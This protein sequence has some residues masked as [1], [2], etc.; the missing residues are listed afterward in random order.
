L[1]LERH[2][3]TLTTEA[4]NKWYNRKMEL[5]LREME[6]SSVLAKVMSDTPYP[7]NWLQETWREVL[8]YQFHDILPGSSIKRVYDESLA[9][10]QILYQEISKRLAGNDQ[11]LAGRL[12]TAGMESPALVQNSLAWERT[13]WVNVNGHWGR[14]SVPS[15]GY[16]VLDLRDITH[17]EDLLA[18]PTSL[19]NDVLQVTFAPDGSILSILDKRCQHEVIPA[20]Q[21][22]NRLAVYADLGDA[23]DF[24][25]DYAEQD[26]RYMELTAAAA[27]IEGPR[28]ILQQ[29]YR[30]G[31]SELV[32]EIMLTQGSPRLDFVNHLHWR[33]PQAMLRTSFPVDIHAEEATYDIQFG[34][35]RRPTHRNTT[36]DLARDEVCAHK[37]ADL[38]QG[39]Y[40]VALLNDSKYGHKIKGN[41]ID[42]NLLRSAPYPGSRV[43][44]EPADPAEPNDV[45]TD[46]CDHLF[47]YALFP[48]QGDHVQGRVAQAGYEINVP[49]RVMLLPVQPG[50][51]PRKA[52]FLQV[53][54]ANVFVE[55]VKQAEDDLSVII[56]MYEAENSSVKANL[57]LGFPA[58]SAV[59]VNMMEEH[60]APLALVKNTV[61]IE[62]K[63]LEIKT[64]K[65]NFE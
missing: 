10:Y 57:T 50:M 42:L 36:W 13:E 33:T 8:L 21:S 25:M 40:G 52:S 18:T 4:R 20:G 23:W 47:T 32:Q 55:A 9:R 19:E 14:A 26:P 58:A 28:A 39:D 5:G 64:I 27:R 59:E 65:I 51:M 29:T 30:L 2:E 37:W 16:E 6:W 34:H 15:M 11:I 63:P 1:Y 12:S 44:S 49:L 24:P 61:Q 46:Q 43:A 54:A 53:D 22:A 60:L 56:R 3:G 38:S 17:P 62:F 7:V 45:Y 41:V 35:I 31:H 48:H